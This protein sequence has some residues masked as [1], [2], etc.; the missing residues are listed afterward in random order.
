MA[1]DWYSQPDFLAERKKWYA[2]LAKKGFDDIERIDWDTGE[3]QW[4]L[5][6]SVCYGNMTKVLAEDGGRG[7]YYRVARW[8]AADLERG[9]PK[10]PKKQVKAWRM[11]S[12]G[13]FNRQIADAQGVTYRT[14]TRWLSRMREMML[15]KYTS[16]EEDE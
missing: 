6:R 15:E 5:K 8:F 13:A 7:E 1:A 3:P 4:A 11:H 14:A 12:E 2:K 16:Q 10:L 9:D